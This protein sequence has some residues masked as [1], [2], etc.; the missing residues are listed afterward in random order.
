MTYSEKLK[1]PRWQALRSEVLIRDDHKCYWCG[2]TKETITLHVHHEMYIGK[3]P[4]DTPEECLTTVC[5]ECHAINHL[6]L[7]ELEKLLLTT[8]RSSWKH[9][10]EGILLLNKVVRRIK[11]EENGEV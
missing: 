2:R 9:E 7:T 5:E 10:E 6:P 1:D 8:V 3:N 11:S 4:W